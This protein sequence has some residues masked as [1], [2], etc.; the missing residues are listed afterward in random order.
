MSRLIQ[1]ENPLLRS[2]LI[3]AGANQLGKEIKPAT[4]PLDDGWVTAEEIASLDLQGT[5]LVVLSACQTGLGDVRTAKAYRGCG[6][7]FCMQARGHW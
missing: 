5:E 4:I 7:R 1:Q 3:L 6:K 2:G